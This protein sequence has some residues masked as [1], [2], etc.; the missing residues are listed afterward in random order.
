MR[1]DVIA[2]I[3]TISEQTTRPRARTVT[4]FMD[5]SRILINTI[6]LNNS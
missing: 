1:T 6:M 3:I 2:A 5:Y 4:H